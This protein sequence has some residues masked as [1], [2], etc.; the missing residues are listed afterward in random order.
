MTV[1]D[2]LVLGLLWLCNPPQ[3]LLV[4]A[5][6][7]I[8][9]GTIV[10][11]MTFYKNRQIEHNKA[12]DKLLNE[13]EENHE[14]LEECTFLKNLDDTRIKYTQFNWEREAWLPK[15]SSFFGMLKFDAPLQYLPQKAYYNF[16]NRGF[17]MN[18]QD[19]SRLDH[20]IKLYSVYIRFSWDSQEIED[21][22]HDTKNGKITDP[23]KQ[24]SAD[25]GCDEIKKMYYEYKER[26][27]QRYIEFNPKN[28]EGLRMRNRWIIY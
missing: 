16:M 7:A 25:E 8:I 14:K 2:N 4:S 20:L 9:T 27:D 1:I 18:F 22:I 15:A 6:I 26:F 21:A 5:L 10:S 12:L 28:N 19:Y 11:R 17:Y 23:S 24:I 13:I 3:L